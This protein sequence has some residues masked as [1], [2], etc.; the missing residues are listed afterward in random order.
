MRYSQIRNL[1]IVN[2]PGCRVSIFVS[3]CEH[4]CKN[5]FN[6]ETWNFDHGTEFTEDTLTSI[7]KLTEPSHISGLS[8]LGGEPLHPRNREEVIRLARKFK[9]KY[10]DKTVWL[11]TG[12][13][14][15]EVFEDLIDSGID[16][17]VD[18]RFVEE[19]K[20]LRLKYRGS[21]NQRVIDINETIRTGKVT[22]YK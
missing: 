17:I 6:P 3:G 9:E 11:W 21:S 5:C 4:R 18:G 1:D 13:L 20:D 12:Y 15:E 22:L 14:V 8:I 7:L 16:V 10:P 2:G 19:L